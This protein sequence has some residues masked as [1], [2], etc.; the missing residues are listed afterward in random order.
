MSFQEAL[1]EVWRDRGSP[2]MRSLAAGTGLSASA[3]HN[4]LRGSSWPQRATARLLVGHLT[5]GD[6]QAIR[7]LMRLYDEEA[8]VKV[9]A[10]TVRED[11]ELVTVIR[12]L[13]EA[14]KELTR[15][16]RDNPKG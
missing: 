15:L 11:S 8:A 12:E 1:L 10:H 2:S 4:V 13:T 6:G 5:Q 16:M 14:V 3:A 7:S 9:Q